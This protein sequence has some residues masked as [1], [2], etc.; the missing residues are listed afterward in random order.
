[1]PGGRHDRRVPGQTQQTCAGG[2][3]RQM[4]AGGQTRQMCAGGQIQQTAV[5]DGDGSIGRGFQ[6]TVE[7]QVYAEEKGHFREKN[8]EMKEQSSHLD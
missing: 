4:C 3:S 2:Q 7:T 1:M 8:K 5:S 6:R